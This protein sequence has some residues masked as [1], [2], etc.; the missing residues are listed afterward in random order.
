MKKTLILGLI[1]T[2]LLA[3]A[4]STTGAGDTEDNRAEATTTYNVADGGKVV[5]FGNNGDVT[6]CFDLDLNGSECNVETVFE[7][8]YEPT[9]PG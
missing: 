4:C 9:V 5:I 6:G 3:S 8:I 1:S 2:A 7:G